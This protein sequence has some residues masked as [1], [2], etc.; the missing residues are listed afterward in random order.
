MQGVYTFSANM[1]GI[2]ASKTLLLLEGSANGVMEILSAKVTQ[3]N[4]TAA[5]QLE[6][7]IGRVTT[8]GSPVGTA[9]SPEPTEGQSAA[10][11]FTCLTNLTVEPTTYATPWV[12]RNGWA[13]VA[14][15]FYDPLPEERKI[16]PVAG[17]VGLKLLSSPSNTYNFD[18]T[19][20]VRFLG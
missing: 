20:T 3:T 16:I 6:C 2:N 19:M 4:I 17:N 1:T 14:G 9:T 7:Q 12:D 13:N 18:V 15:Y 11:P 10:N 5:E 8:L